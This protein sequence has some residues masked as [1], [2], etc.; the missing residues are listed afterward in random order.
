M[1]TE[2]FYFEKQPKN[3]SMFTILPPSW[4]SMPPG[5]GT[6][7]HHL[8]AVGFFDLADIYRSNAA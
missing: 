1:S 3:L 2:L 5:I 8:T 6:F 7:C 4:S